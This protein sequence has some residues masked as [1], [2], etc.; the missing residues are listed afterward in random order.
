MTCED[1]EGAWGPDLT[2]KSQ[3]VICFLRNTGYDPTS[4]K[5]QLDLRGVRRSAFCEIR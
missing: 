2:E 4:V 5:K 3:F 1:P